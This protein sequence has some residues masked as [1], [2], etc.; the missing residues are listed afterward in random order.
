[1]FLKKKIFFFSELEPEVGIEHLD[2][3]KYPDAD[4]PCHFCSQQTS[5]SIHDENRLK[6]VSG[7]N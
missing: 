1:M 2:D 3:L 7:G 4:P 5:T 6:I